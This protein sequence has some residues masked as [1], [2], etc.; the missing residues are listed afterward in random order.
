MEDIKFSENGITFY[1]GKGFV[2]AYDKNGKRIFS[3]LDVFTKP[4]YQPTKE[5]V[6]RFYNAVLKISEEIGD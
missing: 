5:R 2:C 1:A 3:A 6:L 4:E